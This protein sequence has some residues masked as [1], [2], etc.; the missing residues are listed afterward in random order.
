NAF[1][2]L[3]HLVRSSLHSR[4]QHGRSSRGA[5]GSDDAAV[6]N[7]AVG[8]TITIILVSR[9]VPGEWTFADRD[10]AAAT[11]TVTIAITAPMTSATDVDDHRRNMPPVMAG[12]VVH[13]SAG[14]PAIP[15]ITRLPYPSVAADV[16]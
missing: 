7:I 6:A 2:F 8:A 4:R 1:Q 5:I 15:G 14:V 12:C 11:M 3:G 13:G 16:D 9:T 10:D